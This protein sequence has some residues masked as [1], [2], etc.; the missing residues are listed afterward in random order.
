[1]VHNL[2]YIYMMSN[3]KICNNLYFLTY[4]NFHLM[5]IIEVGGKQK[6]LQGPFLQ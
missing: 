2:N 5:N 1:M 3:N 4:Q 6:L